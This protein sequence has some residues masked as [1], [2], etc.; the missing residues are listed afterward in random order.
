M[1][2]ISLLEWT[3]GGVFVGVNAFRRYNTPASNRASTTFQNFSLYFT[4][5][6]LS[7]LT[8]YVFF[9]AVLNSSPET[10]GWVYGL[11]TGQIIGSVPD[12]L[13]KLSAPMVS[14][15]F[16]TTLLPSL[17]WLSR[18]EQALL[19]TFWDRGNIPNHVYKMAAAMRRARFNFS[20]RQLQLLAKRCQ[21]LDIEL[22][23]LHAASSTDFD[24]RWARA[25]ALLDSLE[26]WKDDDMGRMRR[27]MLEQ[28]EELSRLNQLR[29]QINHEFSEVKAEQLQPQILGK[30]ERFLDR[31]NTELFRDTSVLVGR[32]VCI[33]ELSEAGRSARITQLGFESASQGFDRL[34]PGQ[35]LAAFAAIFLTFLVLSITQELNK[36]VPS[37]EFG[38]V[39]FITFLMLFTYGA[40]LVLAF[41]LKRRV[42]MG[43]NELTRQRSWFA[44]SLVGLI[45]ALGWFVVTMSFRYAMNMLGGDTSEANLA[46]VLQDLRWSFPYAVQSLAL[47][48]AVSWIL[49]KHQSRGATDRLCSYQRC[50]DVMIAVSALALA[51]VVA[52]CWMEGLGPFEGHATKAPDYRGKTA[53]GWFVI[54]GAAVGAVI[55]WLVPM[56]FHINR[57]KAPDQ[58]AG[59][60]IVMNQKALSKEIKYLKPGQLIQAVASV[61]ASVAAID[62]TVSRTEQDVY[63]IICAHL[64]GLPDSDVNNEGAEQAFEH[65]LALIENGE[66]QLTQQ[67]SGLSDYPLVSALMPYIASSI[68]FADGIYLDQEKTVVE[69]IRTLVAA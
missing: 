35:I 53:F 45:T 63:Q 30:I 56:W 39:F 29:E 46:K 51:S 6:L 64:A 4:F 5:Y 61:A 58:I 11:A 31:S 41:D 52:F 7:V 19:N 36:P 34:S 42:G 62:F 28:R 22:I 1:E 24:Y 27:F 54:K 67:L 59:R 66:L 55:G 9:G 32:A 60:L 23:P 33:T 25:N 14:A 37:R 48:I 69:Q 12:E 38:K 43:Y 65:S 20:P 21:Q 47:A 16:L 57:S 50:V 3:V 26:E 13:R 68:A 8:L 49:D 40:A 18:Y 44:Y 17:P 2:S 10:I 15:L